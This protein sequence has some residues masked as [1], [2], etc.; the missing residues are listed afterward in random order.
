[1]DRFFQLVELTSGNV[2][3]DFDTMEEATA[4]LR[5][6]VQTYGVDAMRTYS[7]LEFVDGAATLVAMQDE[8]LKLVAHNEMAR[9]I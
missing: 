8:L 2:A 9:A 1:V 4:A 6:A 3:D 7:L 5:Q